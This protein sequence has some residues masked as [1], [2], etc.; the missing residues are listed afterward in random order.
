MVVTLNRPVGVLGK[1]GKVVRHG[2]NSS[3]PHFP[4]VSSLKSTGYR[5][6]SGNS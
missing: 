5:S 2:L 6:C 1:V 3:A 4:H